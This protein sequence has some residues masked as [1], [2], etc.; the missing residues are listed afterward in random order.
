MPPVSPLEYVLKNHSV[1]QLREAYIDNL[2]LVLGDV[3]R[4]ISYLSGR[5]IITADH[6]EFLGE[7]K[8]FSHPANSDHPILLNVPWFEICQEKPVR[9]YEPD[10]T[11]WENEHGD[12]EKISDSAILERLRDL[13]YCD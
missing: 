6:G 5:I 7:N 13:G 8:N 3:A 9:L 1:A 10:G 4:L 2:K 12:S 11:S